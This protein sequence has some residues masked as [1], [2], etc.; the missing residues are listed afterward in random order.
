LPDDHPGASLRWD[1]KKAKEDTLEGLRWHS[2]KAEP[3]KKKLSDDPLEG[4]R[5]RAPGAS[6]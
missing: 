4:F 1:N 6:K 3:V 2:R 5:W